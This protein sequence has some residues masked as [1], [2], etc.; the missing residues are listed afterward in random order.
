MAWQ[1]R[2]MTRKRPEGLPVV[3]PQSDSDVYRRHRVARSLQIA[4][5]SLL[6]FHASVVP[7]GTDPA[8]Y[9]AAAKIKATGKRF[10]AV[11]KCHAKAALTRT[12]AAPDC[13]DR[14]EDKFLLAFAKA[15]SG[16]ACTLTGDTAATD[17]LLDVCADAVVEDLARRCG[18]DI[19]APSEPC[20]DGNATSGDGCSATCT[21]ETGFQCTGAPSACTSRCGDGMVASNELCDDGGQADGD[22]CSAS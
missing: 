19:V 18:D 22:G 13:L 16:G 14:A 21:I 20:D 17:H 8:R 7:A 11:S 5:F 1:D 2:P 6:V 4:F 15:E 3:H 12:T 9:C 10:A